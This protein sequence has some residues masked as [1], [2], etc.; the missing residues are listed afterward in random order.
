M[1]QGYGPPPDGGD[2]RMEVLNMKSR[3]QATLNSRLRSALL[4]PLFAL[5]L[6]ANPAL[7]AFNLNVV[8]PNGE[9]VTRYRWTLEED[10]MYKVSPGV[11]DPT[12][13]SVTFH[14]SY[15]PVMASGTQ[16]T[17]GALSLD[18]LKHYYISVL[19]ED[20]DIGGN[21]LY[22]NGGAQIAAGATSATAYCNRLP[23]PTAQITV[24]V[25][26]D[27]QPI[28]NAPD[29]P[30]EVGLAGF[31]IIIEEPGGR[32]GASGGQVTQDAYG[33]PLGTTYALDIYGNVEVNPDGTPTQILQLGTGFI[34]SGPDGTAR[35][36]YLSPGK[37]GV[38]VVPPAGQGW[39]QTSTIEG[40]KVNDAW[41]KANEPPYFQEFGP[42]G[43][44]VFFGFI[45]PF[46]DS[47]VLN[48]GRTLS[49]RIVNL[50]MSRPPD[51]SFHN[52]A[53]YTHT[54]PWVGLND[55][56]GGIPGRGLYANP[57]NPDGT[58][59]I[60]N[61]P[62]GSY[63][64]VVFDDNL[65]LIF[66]FLTVNMAGAN[67]DLGD[68]PCFQWFTRLHNHVFYDRNG[69]GFKDCVTPNCND[70]LQDDVGMMDIPV[71]LRWRDGTVY[72]SMPTDTEG[73]SPFDEVFPFFA[74]LVAEV[75]F[76]RFKATGVTV[77][78]DAGGPINPADP[79]SF[80]GE[81]NP[82]LQP[83]NGNLPYRTETGPVLLQGF[84]G[85]IGQM[86]VIQWGKKD[87]G[88]GENGGISGI[89]YYASTRAEHD[90]R[91]AA[92][93]TW[94]PGIP[95]IQVTLYQDFNAD[96]IIDDLN[97]D[98]G[99]T[100]ADVD[101]A[102]LGNFP[103]PEDIDRNGNGLFNAGDAVNVVHTDSWDDSPPTDCVGDI[104]YHHGVPTDCYD[105]L[106]NFN[107]VR[108]AVFDGG[109]AFASY[110]P[111]GVDSGSAEVDGL[112]VGTYIVQT[113][114]PPGYEL[115]KEEDKNVDFG[116]SYI[117][118]PE[119]EPPILVGDLH[120]VP[121]YLALFPDAQ[122]P[123]PFAGQMRPLGDRKWVTLNE[124]KNAACDFFLFTAA[125][126]A[127]HIHGFI[128]DDTQNEFDPNA[129][130]FGE[131]YAPPWLPVAIKDWTGRVI[132]RTYSDEWGVYEALVPSTYTA[133]RPM[134]S[135]YAP[136]MITVS[137]NDPGPILDTR[138][139]SPTYGQM[140]E[141]PF[142]NRNYSQFTYT[143]QYMPG[144]TTYLDTP[145]I[146][147]GAFTGAN[148]FP[149][150]CEFP[151]GTPKIYSVNGPSGGPYVV[152]TER[153]ITITAEGPVEVPNP[154]YDGPG[155][156]QPRT[157][158]RDYGFGSTPGTVTINGVAL[159]NVSWSAGAITGTV[160]PG[161]TTG[162]LVVVRGD[163]GMYSPI[164]VT[165]TVGGS[166][167]IMVNPTLPPSNPLRTIQ[168][169][170]D[171][172]SPN[173][174]ILVPP[175]LYDEL[176][177]LYEPVR[178]QGYG[179]GSTRINAVKTPAEKLNTWRQ[180][181]T[182]LVNSGAVDLLP[183]Q[184]V[185][186]GFPE[187]GLLNNEEGPGII[188][189]AK[190]GQFQADP[191]ARI[192]GF[193]VFGGDT[194]GGVFIN[195]YVRYLEISNCRITNNQGFWSGGIR[196]G[197]PDLTVDG[198]N[199][200]EYVDCQNDNLFIHHNQISQNG[201]LGGV[202]GGISLYTGCDNY[203]IADNFICGNFSMGDGGG[204]GQQGRSHNGVITGN[205]F[206]Y[207]QTF[208]Q[209]QVVTGG[210]VFIGGGAP[211]VAGDPSPGSGNV[212]I[213]RNLFQGNL[214]GAGD[215]GAI[216][217]ARANGAD[218]AASP[219][220][221]TPWYFVNIFNNFIENNV[222]GMAGGAISLQDSAKVRIIH[223]TITHNDSTATAGEAFTGGPNNSIPQPAGVVGRVHSPDFAAVFG[224]SGAVAPYRDF[225]NPVLA[226]NIIWQNRS[227]YFSSTALP[228][229]PYFGLLP[230]PATP[231]FWD[232]A[233]IGFAGSLD[234]R[235]CL[236]TNP[237]GY[238]GS[239]ITGDPAFFTWYFNSAANYIQQQEFTN[240]LQ[241]QPAF[242]EGGN[243]IDVRFGPLSPVNPV[244]GL[245]FGDPHINTGSPA[246]GAGDGSYVPTYAELALDFDWNTRPFTNPDIGADQF[247]NPGAATIDL[248][249]DG[250]IDATDLAILM[251]YLNGNISPGVAPFLAPLMWADLNGDLAVDT[252]DLLLLAQYLAGMGA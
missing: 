56:T 152:A 49:G 135:G 225:S 59:S 226:N 86:S 142:F 249:L 3:N 186:G 243:F 55:F 95:R 10:R 13:V 164:G 68:M 32:Y 137:L 147:T 206:Q 202:G 183:N 89:V 188:V 141:D 166:A 45:R 213:H 106:R 96:Q 144:T 80:D 61:V 124:G 150:D 36:K 114:V 90:P 92:A 115:V 64:L 179:A 14:P 8:G 107:Q 155:G 58:F 11:I 165:L 178:L 175:G 97:G 7:Q 134:P 120:L 192:D 211:L 234:P 67:M 100:L 47:S 221:S 143:F 217:I 76:A 52:G 72:M 242:D 133:N 181:V 174:L 229:P 12:T 57:V 157:I 195:G 247:V 82:Q 71:N 87:Y 173:D 70:P 252:Q 29:L 48:N 161:T 66:A 91:Y 99:V 136:N 20:T 190:D 140:I 169:A 238:H 203:R 16:A 171:L 209:G 53:P 121:P 191:H 170:V 15:M 208:N 65:D 250:V 149:L 109:Y 172:A 33:N 125:P 41:V 46:R 44:H 163:N 214:A 189:L 78:V 19:P 112:P 235:S 110:F 21:R 75:D 30:E 237:A 111:G 34:Y 185:G 145:V 194:G 98:G 43:F 73:W 127:G 210:G 37:Y 6:L 51:Y 104:F 26:E 215:G 23:I 198:P 197:F 246:R 129:P 28:N 184:P 27:T 239:N 196:A 156:V 151:D 116:D 101:N 35:I 102:P 113:A 201:G 218:V 69:N 118:A 88:P 204:F 182:A 17:I 93:D 241:V 74:W 126:I 160:A 153:V 154:E 216:R 227:F 9:A 31:Q 205:A 63:Q 248:N 180:R 232:L 81:L 105:G 187:P 148:Q 94:E 39:Q 18:P 54:T 119:L 245:L 84:Q 168:G 193:S 231:V 117:P 22:T 199:G 251:Q 77:T 132:G 130:N 228:D 42:P 159:T 5:G 219:N 4:L 108:P 83:E 223:N 122:I 79:W 212:T 176:V 233:V 222:A 167:P 38:I 1:N 220:S 138:P 60:P 177:I 25:F 162:Q 103:G 2:N 24:F 85:F 50:H 146:P 200:L 158:L 244:D 236:L 240:G 207:N 139:G 230:D 62:P 40:T 224:G 128:L 131:K 123:A